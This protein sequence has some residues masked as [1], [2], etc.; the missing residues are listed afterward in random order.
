MKAWL[1]Q[2]HDPNESDADGLT[3]L[4]KAVY[5]GNAQ[6][7]RMLIAERANVDVGEANGA[8]PLILAAAM[9]TEEC[10]AV[11]IGA[12]ASLDWRDVTGATA[13]PTF[14]S[15]C[16]ASCVAIGLS[17]LTGSMSWVRMHSSNECGR[18]WASSM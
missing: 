16:T 9:G 18:P 15:T 10:L 12:Y 4:H 1:A 2:G 5:G 6:N 7:V 17:L 14:F 11:L 3:P 13:L 8:S